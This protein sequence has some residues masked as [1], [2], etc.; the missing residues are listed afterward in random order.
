M[1]ASRRQAFGNIKKKYAEGAMTKGDESE[2]K[3]QPTRK[4]PAKKAG[5]SSGSGGKKPR[6][7]SVKEDLASDEQG[8]KKEEENEPSD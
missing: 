4:R 7:G 1:T 3:P 8:V 5:G 2:I 6:K